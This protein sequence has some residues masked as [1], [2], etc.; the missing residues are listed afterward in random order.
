MAS[1]SSGSSS[2]LN[3]SDHVA[4]IL[5]SHVSHLVIGPVR[6]QFAT[7]P[8]GLS[9]EEY[10]NIEEENSKAQRRNYEVN[11]IGKVHDQ[12]KMVGSSTGSRVLLT[13]RDTVA[14]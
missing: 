6:K 1:S 3:G 11:T 14:D 5:L 13:R 12:N 4:D 2:L 10:N 7:G 8:L 9:D